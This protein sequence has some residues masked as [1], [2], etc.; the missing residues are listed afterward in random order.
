M[1]R[2]V[3]TGLKHALWPITVLILAWL[4]YMPLKTSLEGLSEVNA[5]PFRAKLEKAA[6]NQQLHFQTS[7]LATLTLDQLQSFLII[8]GEKGQEL[9]VEFR[10]GSTDKLQR[11]FE[12]LDRLELVKITAKKE[13]PGKSPNVF[14]DTTEK[15]RK[16]HKLIM[17]QLYEELV[18]RPNR[19]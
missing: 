11:D 7:E 5:G 1:T 8:G 3:L 9:S 2:L 19:S 6:K 15:G 16:V 18:L 14:Y 4:F 12:A 17:D 13:Q 10:H